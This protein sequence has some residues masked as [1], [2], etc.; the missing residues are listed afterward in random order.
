MAAHITS[1]ELFLALSVRN[2][3]R[4]SLVHSGELLSRPLC[5]EADLLIQSLRDIPGIPLHW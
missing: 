1:G 4:I 5:S 3:R 2:G